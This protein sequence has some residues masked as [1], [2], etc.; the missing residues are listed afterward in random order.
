MMNDNDASPHLSVHPTS[1]DVVIQKL[2][3]QASIVKNLSASDRSD[4][5]DFVFKPVQKAT[6]VKCTVAGNTSS[7]ADHETKYLRD[8]LLTE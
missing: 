6:P 5:Y 7:L 8:F 2:G 3:A 4:Y 1:K